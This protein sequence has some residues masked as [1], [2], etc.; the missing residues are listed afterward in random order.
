MG[1]NDLRDRNGTAAPDRF[2]FIRHMPCSRMTR[3]MAADDGD[4]GFGGGS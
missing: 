4:I 2:F 3:H 1:A